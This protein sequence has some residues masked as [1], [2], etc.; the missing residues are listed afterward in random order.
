MRKKIRNIAIL[1]ATGAVGREMLKIV[2]EKKLPY[3]KLKLFSSIRSA[4]EII[5]IAGKN[6]KV[7]DA[8]HASF[9]DIDLILASAGSEASKTIVP[10]AIEAGCIVIDNC[11]YWRMQ[12]E[13]PLVVP[14]V[15]IDAIEEDSKLI[16]NPNCSTI[17]LVHALS[18]IHK[19][20][21]LKTI[22]VSTYQSVSGAGYKGIR[23]LEQEAEKYP[24]KYDGHFRKA[25]AY[26]VIPQI[27]DYLENGFTT[28]E[29]KLVHESRKILCDN[30]INITATAVRVPVFYGHAESVL[31]ELNTHASAEDIASLLKDQAN[32]EIFKNEKDIYPSPIDSEHNDN[33]MVGRIREDNLG[34]NWIN[35]WIVSNNLRKGAALNAVQIA[36]HIINKL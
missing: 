36:E 32:I 22:I 24:E 1:G 28:E 9:D 26:N 25:I 30:S 2:H 33:T 14:E 7:E 13:V 11:S 17:Q 20:Y 31:I 29:M 16:A 35:M 8:K 4:G 34:K 27:G 3:E 19:R 23:S 12:K 5:N 10:K 21:G 18:P 15:N 6:F